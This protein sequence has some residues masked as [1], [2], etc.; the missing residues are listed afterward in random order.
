MSPASL[1]G[2]VVGPVLEAPNCLLTNAFSIDAN[3][4]TCHVDS[5]CSWSIDRIGGR[6]QARAVDEVRI[7]FRPLDGTNSHF[8]EINIRELTAREMGNRA[9]ITGVRVARV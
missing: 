9:S 6:W 1:S 8:T 5:H 7:G 4:E 3:C 2:S